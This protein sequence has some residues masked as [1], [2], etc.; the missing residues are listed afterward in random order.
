MIAILVG[1]IVTLMCVIR[2]VEPLAIVYRVGFAVSCVA[3]VGKV[4]AISMRQVATN[5]LK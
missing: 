5:S 3:M 1:V 4:A 2:Q